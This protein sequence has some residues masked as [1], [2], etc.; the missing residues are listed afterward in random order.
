MRVS[1]LSQATVTV[2]V[3]VTVGVCTLKHGESAG[4]LRPHTRQYTDDFSGRL[5]WSLVIPFAVAE[6]TV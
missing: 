3:G 5:F 4:T 2:M 1:P 6:L